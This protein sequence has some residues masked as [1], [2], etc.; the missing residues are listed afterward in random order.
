MFAVARPFV[1]AGAHASEFSINPLYEDRVPG[2]CLWGAL[3]IGVNDAPPFT[4]FDVHLA[5]SCDMF[6]FVEDGGAWGGAPHLW[7]VVV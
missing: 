3:D 7:S 4:S 6:G 5:E 2:V 1:W